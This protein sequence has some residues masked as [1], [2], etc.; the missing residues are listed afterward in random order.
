MDK[1]ETALSS[2]LGRSEN[3]GS[4]SRVLSLVSKTRRIHFEGIEKVAGNDS[5]DVLILGNE[6]RL[7]I[8]V[9]TLKSSAWEDR[10]LRAEAGEVYEVPNIV[11][12]LMEI[13]G[14]MGWW[15]PAHAVARLFKAMGESEWNRIPGIVEIMGKKAESYRINA[16]QIREI[17]TESGL[18]NKVDTLIAELKGSGVMS[19]QLS[20]FPEVIKAGAPLYEL[21]PSVIVNGLPRLYTMRSLA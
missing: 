18:G 7:L 9:R 4:L 17:C 19:P 13:A 11:I 3:V 12:Y 21:N 16:V 10:I 15:A 6:W 14:D 5:E 8:P 2:F 20:S 1:L